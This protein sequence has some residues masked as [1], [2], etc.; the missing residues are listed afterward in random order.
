MSDDSNYLHSQRVRAAEASGGT[1]SGP[2]LDAAFTLLKRHKMDGNLLE[3]GA[4]TGDFLQHLLANRYPATMTGSDILPRPEKLPSA[5][6]WIQADLNHPLGSLAD[7]TFDVIVSTEVI[8]HLENPRA[9]I[10]EFWRLLSPGGR[11]LLT[12]PNQESLRS[13]LSLLCSGHYA[14]FQDSCY[15][16]H[17]TALLRKDLLRICSECGFVN[18]AFSFTNHGYIPKL[19]RWTFQQLSVGFLRGRWFSDNLLLVMEKPRQAF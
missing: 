11:A 5:V 18:M 4:G 17:V 3:F 14:A 2:I 15:P 6:A 7:S 10:R 19:T 13:F 9:M 12:T 16:A 1:S 8:E